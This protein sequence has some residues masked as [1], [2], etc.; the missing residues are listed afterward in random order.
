MTPPKTNKNA[1]KQENITHVEG[2]QTLVNTQNEQVT[3]IM[4]I[5]RIISP[6]LLGSDA[7]K[8]E[9]GKLHY[10]YKIE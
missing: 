3:K 1:A 5:V 8:H 10:F 7:I 6:Q 4:E 2:M 9:N